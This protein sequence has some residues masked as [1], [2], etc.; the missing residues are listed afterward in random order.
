MPEQ[1]S[2]SERAVLEALG[3]NDDDDDMQK[4]L[5]DIRATDIAAS[6]VHSDAAALRPV[7]FSARRLQ[8]VPVARPI[9]KRGRK[10]NSPTLW[11]ESRALHYAIC[12]HFPSEH[13]LGTRVKYEVAHAGSARFCR[14]FAAE[15]GDVVKAVRG[16]ER[17][18]LRFAGNSWE[19][20]QPLDDLPDLIY[21][22]DLESP[23]K[24]VDK[25]GPYR[26][27]RLELHRVVH[28]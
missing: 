2:C 6:D 26:I 15:D 10:P 18:K 17:V 28:S 24:A 22:I 8:G 27:Y 14:Q 1:L 3:A 23:A 25:S 20:V 11:R 5:R 7:A 12:E 21:V 4:L 19:L 13:V 9:A 16:G